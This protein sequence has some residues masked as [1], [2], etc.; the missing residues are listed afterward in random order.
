MNKRLKDALDLIEKQEKKIQLMREIAQEMLIEMPDMLPWEEKQILVKAIE[1]YGPEAQEKVLLEEMSELQKEICKHWRGRDN[2]R[3][4]AEEIADVRI[5]L[6]QMVL[7]FQCG[8]AEQQIRMQKLERMQ[9]RL[10][11]E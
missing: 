4:I 6:D 9:S 11:G 8:G 10:E 1:T 2:L 5:M 7:I 3:E